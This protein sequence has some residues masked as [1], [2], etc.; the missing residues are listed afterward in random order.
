[1]DGNQPISG[2]RK[3]LPKRYIWSVFELFTYKKNA[4]IDTKHSILRNK[5]TLQEK[6]FIVQKNN[7]AKNENTRVYGQIS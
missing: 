7:K 6:C 5:R 2:N 1:M 3:T 4:K